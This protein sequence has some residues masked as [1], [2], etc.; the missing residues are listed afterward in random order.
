[1]PGSMPDVGGTKMPCFMTVAFKKAR[2]VIVT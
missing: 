1:V 2:Q